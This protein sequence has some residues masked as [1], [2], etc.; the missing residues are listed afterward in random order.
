VTTHPNDP[1]LRSFIDVDP[2]SDF[3]I[4]NLPYGVFSAN[5]LA[6]RVGVAIGAYI[7]DL[8]ELEQD[9][10]LDVGQPGTF[11]AGSLNPFMSLGPKVWSTTRARISELLRHDNPELR[12]ND[13]LRKLALVPM[14]AA[15]LHLPFTVSGYT[16]FYSSKEHAT[17]VGVMFRG[18]DNALQPNWLHMPIAYN[19]RASTVVVSG[20]QVKRPRGQLKPPNVDVPSFGPCKRLDF[21][22]EMGVVIGQPSPMGGMLTEQQA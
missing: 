12:D 9:G 16:D 19:G 13:E 7:L 14:S 2:A 21:E 3:P 10:R 22:L 17:N 1:S 18:K 20:T 11:A 4:Q 6:P 15:K 5:G 8:W